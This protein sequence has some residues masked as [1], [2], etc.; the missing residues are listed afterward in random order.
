MFLIQRCARFFWKRVSICGWEISQHGFNIGLWKQDQNVKNTVQ[1]KIQ[2]ILLKDLSFMA[3]ENIVVEQLINSVS[4]FRAI[5]PSKMR[6]CFRDSLIWHTNEWFIEE[7]MLSGC[8]RVLQQTVGL[9][10][11]IEIQ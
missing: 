5:I 7:T 9:R 10:L 11:I 2:Y 6:S 3:R 8:R 1:V 4:N